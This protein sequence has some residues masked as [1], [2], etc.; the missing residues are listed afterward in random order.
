[1][2]RRRPPVAD[3]GLIHIGDGR[4]RR[5][6]QA[7]IDQPAQQPASGAPGERNSRVIPQ[8]VKI[9]VTVRDNGMCVQCGSVE[10][11]HFDHMIPWSKGGS[12]SVNNIQLLCGPCNRR[13]GAR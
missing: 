4:Y 6:I 2:R 3:S 10:D 8:D 11:I 13:K 9:Q 7:T 1:V 5:P 12:N